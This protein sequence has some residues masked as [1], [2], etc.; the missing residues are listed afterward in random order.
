MTSGKHHTPIQ[1]V[2]FGVGIQVG[3]YVSTTGTIVREERAGREH[4]AGE[5]SLPQH[6][7]HDDVSWATMTA[8]SLPATT[9]WTTSPEP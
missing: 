7:E 9:E 6:T 5:G 2:G 1:A 3:R 8:D 4:G